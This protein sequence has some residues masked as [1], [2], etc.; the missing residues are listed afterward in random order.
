MSTTT[1]P[2]PL[3][4]A[5][6][7][8]RYRL[9]RRL[10]QGGMAE[11]WLG[12]DLS[13]SRQVAVKLLK[14]NLA[15]DPVVAERFR[16]EAIA[17]AQL[18]HPNIVAVYD[19]IEDNGRQAVVMQ[20]V[21][22]KSLRQLLDEQKKLSPEL[23]IHI[24]SC[25]A[26]ALD[27]AHQAGMV[28]RDVKPGNILIT[29]DG[30]VLLTDFGIAKGL[31]PTG[32]DLTND[33]IMMGTAKY[34]SP[35]QVRGKRLDGRADLYSLG[36]V[37]Y[38]CLAG[39]VPFLGQND[40]DT[41]LARLQRDPTDI[42]RLRPTL[43]TGLPELIHKLL[44]RRPDQRYPSG[45][46][47]RAALAE[48]AAK[49]NDPT[50]PDATVTA[51]APRPQPID[52]TLR[53]P[54]DQAATSPMPTREPF[55][56]D[57]PALRD[58]I[59][60]TGSQRALAGDPAR[61][62]GPQPVRPAPVPPRA[63]GG[64]PAGPP[65]LSSD[66]TPTGSAQIQRRPN[67]RF[68]HRRGPSLIVVGGLLLVATIVSAILWNTLGTDSD[69]DEFPTP[70]TAAPV[71]GAPA[72]TATGAA[73]DVTSAEV[74]SEAV[75]PT[76]PVAGIAGAGLVGVRTYD[77]N[78]DDPGENDDDVDLA[79]DGDPATAWSTLCYDDPE[80]AGQAVGLGLTLDIAR[81]GTLTIDVASRSWR[82]E[83][84]TTVGPMPGTLAGWGERIASES[85]DE[86]G[87]VTVPITSAAQQL[88]VAFREVGPSAS[89][90]EAYPFSGAIAEV[91]F[92]ALE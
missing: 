13:L 90:T 11:V 76:T 85:G 41:A 69:G 91:R 77:T 17:V 75:G 64:R 61:R 60:D 43:P 42:T 7:A 53:K 33:N 4:P 21:N 23:T 49:A 28:H 34:L 16:R 81:Q 31:E 14:P 32:D 83:I 66:R 70:T 3:P 58:P 24:G 12:T 6:L 65:V 48:V 89:C 78:A 74:A 59:R 86:P 50:L 37:L 72:S 79:T 36:L 87:P 55:A 47:V 18:N 84:Y 26:G 67:R 9:E 15:S 20:L 2:P 38:E 88:L 80:L 82:I 71:D 62:T 44:A 29:P 25:V 1:S 63:T 39:R 52:P 92:D 22:G 46:S 56:R 10:A 40:A 73:A 57:T 68:E 5:V 30:R 54:Y 27:A 51:T 19:A 45:A 8:Q 35:E